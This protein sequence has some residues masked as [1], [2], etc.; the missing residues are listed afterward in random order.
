MTTIRQLPTR[1]TIERGGAAVTLVVDICSCGH[2]CAKLIRQCCACCRIN[3][4]CSI[5][6]RRTRSAKVGR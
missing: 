6:R 1:L 3:A 4:A 5:C 2:A